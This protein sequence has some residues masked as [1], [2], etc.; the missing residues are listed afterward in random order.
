MNPGTSGSGPGVRALPHNGFDAVLFDLDGTLLDTIPFILESHRASLMAVL[1]ETWDDGYLLGTIGRP[2]EDAFLPAPEDK[3]REL[4]DTYLRYNADHLAGGIGIFLGVLPMLRDIATHFPTVR[5][6]VLTSKRR[7]SARSS[8]ALFG[9]DDWFP[10]VFTKEDSLR[11]KPDPEPLRVAMD[12]M[13]LP[14]PGRVLYVGDSL[15]DLECARAAGCRIAIVEWT[16]MPGEP[17]WQAA[18]D[19]RIRHP[20]EIPLLLL[21]GDPRDRAGFEKPDAVFPWTVSF[22]RRTAEAV[23]AVLDDGGRIALVRSNGYPGGV[24]RV[25]TGG[26]APGESPLDALAREA[27]EELGVRAR[28]LAY[29]GRL[30]HRYV[31]GGLEYRYPAYLMA[32]VADGPADPDRRDD[33][34]SEIQWVSPFEAEAIIGSLEGLDP[35]WRDWGAFRAVT[36]RAALDLARSIQTETGRGR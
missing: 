25:P 20:G 2:L 4:L 9:L 30:W 1:G 18:P 3:R 33:E 19:F 29:G 7:A 34:V 6:A 35:P 26:I 10:L 31:T 32:A 28:P 27:E 12:R 15:H 8:L 5:T 16:R 11:H 17:L 14:D 21:R 23:L 13:G 36:T 22:S 24:F